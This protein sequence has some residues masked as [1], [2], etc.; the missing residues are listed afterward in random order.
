MGKMI[1]AT[2]NVNQALLVQGRVTA[3]SGSNHIYVLQASGQE[4]PFTIHENTTI[5]VT[6]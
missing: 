5:K 2:S 3:T 4:V 1:V 6:A